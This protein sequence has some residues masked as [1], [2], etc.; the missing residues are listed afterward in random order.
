MLPR[1]TRPPP[2]A[3]AGELLFLPCEPTPEAAAGDAVAGSGDGDGMMDIDS[4]AGGKGGKV[5][6]GK[7]K[8]PG[9]G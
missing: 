2:H 6:G 7:R 8:A 9:V 5:R 4:A 3:L 1:A